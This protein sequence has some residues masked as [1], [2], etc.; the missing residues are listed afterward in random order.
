MDDS[1]QETISKL[2]FLGK[3]S[4][5]EKI[6]VKEKTLQTESF[7][8]SLSRTVW[9]LDN[10]NNT[11]SFIQTTV[12]SAFSLLTILIQN[13]NVSDKELAKSIIR[14]I[15]LAKNGISNLKTTYSDDAYF[16]CGVDTY[17]ETINAKLLDLKDRHEDLFL[18]D[19]QKKS[20]IESNSKDKKHR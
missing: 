17:I 18:K 2:K 16:C 15:D 10:R 7:V 20:V 3:I 19:E 6:N 4:K 5:G 13:D 14:D 1:Q 11:L 8:T 12:Q 9:F